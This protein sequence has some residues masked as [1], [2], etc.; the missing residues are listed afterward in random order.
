[1]INFLKDRKVGKG[2]KDYLSDLSKIAKDEREKILM[3]RVREIVQEE[4]KNSGIRER[5]DD[6]SKFT[7][8]VEKKM[9]E[10]KSSIAP[11]SR[12]KTD[13]IRKL[14]MK[15]VVI[16][17]LNKNK[18]MNACDL[19]VKLNLSRTRCSEYLTELE[20]AGVTKGIVISRQKFYELNDEAAKSDVQ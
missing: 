19:S 4:L 16:E 17:L 12:S 11:L 9:E 5:L 7:M 15:R 1:M 18:R 10:L 8:S 14:K 20:K 13:S 6:I 2:K 3:E